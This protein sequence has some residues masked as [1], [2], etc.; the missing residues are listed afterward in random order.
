MSSLHVRLPA[1]SPARAARRRPS[2]S[3]SPLA[4]RRAGA[5]P[6]AA[7]SRERPVD[8]P[9]A[10]DA[11][12]LALAVGDRGSLRGRRGHAGRRGRLLLDLPGAGAADEP[13][14][15]HAERRGDREVP[16]RTSSSSADDD[17]DIVAQLGTLAHPGAARAG[18]RE[19]RAAPTPRS[20]SSA[21]DR[22]R[23]GRQPVVASMRRQVAA[24]VALGAAPTT[25]AHAS[26]TSST[27][28][29]YSATSHTFIGAA[30]RAAR[31]RQHRRRGRRG[32]APTRSSRASTSSRA[33]PT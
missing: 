29:Y 22:P 18:G 31:A 13:L 27:R 3:C 17:N 6:A 19:P 23:R 9:S 11:D 8:H 33:I 21:G 7:A 5:L 2:R 26:T 1:A 28:T 10:A 20:S 30:V 4:R 15:L 12:R 32:R 24:I 16:T 14:G 25:A